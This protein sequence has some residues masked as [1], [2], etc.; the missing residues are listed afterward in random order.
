MHDSVH[1]CGET[2]IC[3]TVCTGVGKHMHDSVHR[4][5]ETI[6]CMTVCTGVGKQSYVSQCAQV[7][8]IGCT[9]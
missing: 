3:M 1:M 2:V 4:C 7:W 9:R 5:G 6:I 8:G